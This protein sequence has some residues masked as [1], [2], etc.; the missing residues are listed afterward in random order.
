[1]LSF[2]TAVV[3]DMKVAVMWKTTFIQPQE[4]GFFGASGLSFSKL[5][6]LSQDFHAQYLTWQ[7]HG[8]MVK[9]TGLLL[10]KHNLFFFFFKGNNVNE[11]DQLKVCAPLA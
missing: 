5:Q 9:H 10:N 4:R 1:M 8:L 6:L 7:C 11:L 2:P 3:V